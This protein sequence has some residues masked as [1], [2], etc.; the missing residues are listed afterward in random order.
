MAKPKVKPICLFFF[1]ILIGPSDTLKVT[2][3][4]SSRQL[5]TSRSIRTDIFKGTVP[6]MAP[7]VLKEE[8]ASY[9]ADVW[10]YGVTLWEL[11][12]LQ[13]PYDHKKRKLMPAQFIYAASTGT[14]KLPPLPDC[15]VLGNLSM[16]LEKCLH[17]ESSLRPTF[18]MIKEEM[19]LLQ[20]ELNNFS[21]EKW[22]TMRTEL[23]DKGKFQ[24]C[25]V[26][27]LSYVQYFFVFFLAFQIL[28]QSI[29]YY[30][31]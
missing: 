22:K 14:L 28:A 18:K 15:A 21:E 12:T 9:E 19:E 23:R 16:L 31:L 8:R 2:D 20:T 25:I 13:D 29:I 7:E 17:F 10:S 11:V 3:F 24:S 30:S 6:Y 5:L 4:G 1:S 26:S 27:Q